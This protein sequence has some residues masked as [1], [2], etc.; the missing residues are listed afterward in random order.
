MITKERVDGMGGVRAWRK[1]EREKSESWGWDGEEIG[2]G[3]GVTVDGREAGLRNRV[4]DATT[5]ETE[6]ACETAQAEGEEDEVRCNCHLEAYKLT[7]IAGI[8]NGNHA[9]EPRYT[10]KSH[11]L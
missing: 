10:A 8:F 7:S 3:G 2:K 1:K 4:T 9:E 6:M 11:W 5:N